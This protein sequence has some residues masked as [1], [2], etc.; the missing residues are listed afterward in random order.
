LPTRRNIGL[1][2]YSFQF[3]KSSLYI[4]KKLDVKPFSLTHYI[5]KSCLGGQVGREFEI[6]GSG[7][8]KDWK[9]VTC[10]FPG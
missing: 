9:I 1:Y 8:V 2:K 10:C 6:G 7:Q 4:T 5:T 3:I